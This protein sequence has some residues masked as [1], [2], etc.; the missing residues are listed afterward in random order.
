VTGRI[1]SS[2]GVADLG[3]FFSASRISVSSSTSVGPG[4]RL[5]PAWA[6]HLVG[7]AHHQEDH[8]GEDQEVD[9]LPK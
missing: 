9:H 8:E 1:T 4:G 3:Y 2:E 6:D 7:L 5:L